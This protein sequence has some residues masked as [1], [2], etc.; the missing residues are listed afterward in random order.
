MRPAVQRLSEQGW[1]VVALRRKRGRRRKKAIKA[2]SPLYRNLLAVD[3][4]ISMGAFYHTRSGKMFFLFKR[5]DPLECA[6]ELF[7]IIKPEIA[8]I[9]EGH[10]FGSEDA[11]RFASYAK[12]VAYTVGVPYI[13]SIAPSLKPSG[14]TSKWFRK[15]EFL[16]FLSGD[17]LDAESI[18]MLFSA[19]EL[20]HIA[21]AVGVL[22][23]LLRRQ[24]GDL[25]VSS[26][27]C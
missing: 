2:F 11:V 12:A 5:G 27:I 13:Y 21:S 4:G 20:R 19:E 7:S 17:N 9:E 26:N 23:A 18:D 8:V 22:E 1:K 3:T 6:V 10:Y 25:V 24:G 14:L 15:V 16:D